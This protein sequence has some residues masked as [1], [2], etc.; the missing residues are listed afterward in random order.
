MAHMWGWFQPGNP[1]DGTPL[2]LP[3]AAD[4]RGLRLAGL[5]GIGGSQRASGVTRYGQILLVA[6]TM[7][8]QRSFIYLF[9]MTHIRVLPDFVL[10]D[11]LAPVSNWCESQPSGLSG[12]AKHVAP[13]AMNGR[14]IRL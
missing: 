1:S 9:T 7:I 6:S 4:A 2:G 5:T 13:Q 8:A 14:L 3:G 12:D 10:G 11:G